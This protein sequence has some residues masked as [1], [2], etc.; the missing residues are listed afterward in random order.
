VNT[1]ACIECHNARCGDDFTWEGVEDCDDG[2]GSVPEDCIAD[3]GDRMCGM[4][5]VCGLDECGE[6]CDSG[7]ACTDEGRCGC[8][9]GCD[10]GECEPG[11]WATICA[12]TFDMGSPPGEL[13]RVADEVQHE[14]RLTNNFLMLSTEVTQ[15]EFLEAMGYNP[16]NFSACGA[17]CPVEQV[18]WHEAAAYCNS[19]SEDAELARCY[20]CSGSGSGVTC[21]PNAAFGTPYQC[22]G[23]RLPTEAEWEYAARAGTISLRY[24]EINDIAWY[25]G[26]SGFATH[27]VGTQASNDWGLSD[28]LGNAWEW[29]HDWY[30]DYPSMP[31]TDPFG[32]AEGSNRVMRGGGYNGEASQCRAAFRSKDR[33]ENHYASLGL[34]PVRTLDLE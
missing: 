3:C 22:P 12:G 11:E 31:L 10:G 28:S 33:P 20:T 32:T 23:Y 27:E 24:G 17:D 29:C 8:V 30:G 9:P 26:N 2:T 34:R 15:G 18:A 25:D 1:D 16:S 7:Y 4:E 5:P 19:L 6:G 13:G 14:V 21:T